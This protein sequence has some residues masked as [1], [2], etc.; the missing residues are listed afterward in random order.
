M[1]LAAELG[2]L[3]RILFVG[4]SKHVGY[5]LMKM[6]ALVLMSQYEGLPNV[7][8]EAQYMGVPVV[9]T[10]AGGAEECF[11]PNETGYVLQDAKDPD[12]YEAC[13]KISTLIT[14]FKNNPDLKNKA[15]HFASTHFS[16]S[17]MIDNTVK[18][19]K[20]TVAP[21]TIQAERRVCEEELV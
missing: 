9:S 6:D 17:G 8:I 21:T 4:L 18:T 20:R 14:Q 11:I 15:I 5:W 7:L 16:I 13:D 2:I 12:L 10:P 1:D 3:P 19:L